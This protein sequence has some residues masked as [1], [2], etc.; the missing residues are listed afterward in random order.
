VNSFTLP[1]HGQG[2]GV[3][4]QFE[5]RMEVR[6]APGALEIIAARWCWN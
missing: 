5:L 6:L 4:F 2:R 1:Q 3:A